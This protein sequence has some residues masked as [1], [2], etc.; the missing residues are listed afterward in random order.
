MRHKK[1]ILFIG[2]TLGLTAALLLVTPLLFATEEAD[3]HFNGTA[4]E[5]C[6]CKMFCPCYFNTSPAMNHTE[7][8]PEKIPP[9]GL[10]GSFWMTI[11]A[12]A[13]TRR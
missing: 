2:S 7:H 11:T 9:R 10:A 4:I 13:A 12:S 3:W 1:P 8:G 6:S 5:A